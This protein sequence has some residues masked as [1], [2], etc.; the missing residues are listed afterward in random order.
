MYS[1]V[2]MEKV[3][4]YQVQMKCQDLVQ[5]KSEKTTYLPISGHPFL[6]AVVTFVCAIYTFFYMH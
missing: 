6:L 5:E 2:F 4:S 1:H 3:L